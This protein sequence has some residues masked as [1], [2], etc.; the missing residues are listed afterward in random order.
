MSKP[1][2]VAL[3]A[4]A[5]FALPATAVAADPS[6]GQC[7]ST[8]AGNPGPNVPIAPGDVGTGCQRPGV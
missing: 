2:A 6:F 7:Q 8:L 1:L 3:A 5:L 4:A